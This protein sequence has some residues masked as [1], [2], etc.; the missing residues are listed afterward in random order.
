MLSDD[1]F[2]DPT[3]KNFDAPQWMREGHV[4]GSHVR[5]RRQLFIGLYVE[6]L[7]FNISRR[8]YEM[9]LFVEGLQASGKLSRTRLVVPGLKR[10]RKWAIEIFAHEVEGHD[11]EQIDTGGKGATVYLGAAYGL[12]KDPVSVFPV[13]QHLLLTHDR[14][15]SHPRPRGKEAPTL[16]AVFHIF[17]PRQHPPSDS[18]SQSLP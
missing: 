7:L 6:F 18:G 8:V 2:D 1:F 10:L 15:I 17:S 5:L 16:S 11:A 13:C 14:N 9:I 3:S 4:D 12:K